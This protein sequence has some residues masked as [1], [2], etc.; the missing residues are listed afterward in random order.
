MTLR[1]KFKDCFVD[2]HEKYFGKGDWMR[3]VQEYPEK[4]VRIE[5]GLLKVWAHSQAYK[6]CPEAA[7]GMK[8]LE[9]VEI[10]DITL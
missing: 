9:W 4:V 5:D 6:E 8:D 1:F 3:E 10:G 7:W 2:E